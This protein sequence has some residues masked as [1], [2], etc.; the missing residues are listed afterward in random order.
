MNTLVYIITFF[1]TVAFSIICTRIVRVIALRKHITDNP[2]SAPERKKQSQAIPLLG[3]W[4]IYASFVCGTAVSLVI[5]HLL[6]DSFLSSRQ[7]FGI[8]LGG[9]I[10]VVGGTLDDRKNLRAATQML[11]PVLAILTVIFFGVGVD[12]ITSPFG[13]VL[14]LD[15]IKIAVLHIKDITYHLT[16]WS[17]IFTFVWLLIL[18]YA[19]KLLDGVDGL[20]SGVGVIGSVL[21][22]GL[23]LTSAVNQPGTALLSIIVTGSIFGFW[24]SNKYPARIYLGEGGSV[25]IGFFLGLLAI[26]SGAKI[27]TALLILALPILDV[28][29][30]MLTRIR[31][32]KK[33]WQSDRSHLH[34]RLQ[35]RGLSP[36][37]VLYIFYSLSLLF[38]LSALFANAWIKF[39]LLVVAIFLSLALVLFALKKPTLLE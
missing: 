3:G 20:A 23:S 8:L 1:V 35:D 12:Y 34:F 39:I 7:L 16:L 10:I 28:A 31:R 29:W 2:A 5:S 27:A 9:L 37:S 26:I 13:G 11:F 14:I 17:D 25:L 38:G 15:N 33:F 6:I 32:G 24:L 4:A 18:M 21:L 19:T 22:F 36:K 30:V